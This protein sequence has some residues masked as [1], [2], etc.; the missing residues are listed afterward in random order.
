MNRKR[1]FITGFIFYVVVFFI[2][3]GFELFQINKS[4][5]YMTIMGLK[6]ITKFSPHDLNTT[7]SLTPKIILTLVLFLAVIMIINELILRY[8]KSLSRK[9]K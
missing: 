8:R 6:I 9:A 2:D 4:G 5:E 3:Y 1:A 7:F